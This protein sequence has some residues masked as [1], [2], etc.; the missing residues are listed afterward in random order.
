MI[1][2]KK[3]ISYSVLAIMLSSCFWRTWT[4]S[5][6]YKKNRESTLSMYNNYMKIIRQLPDR[7]LRLYGNA[8]M[9][10]TVVVHYKINESGGES[11][12]Y[13][14]SGEFI[15][16]YNRTTTIKESRK[17]FQTN[18]FKKLVSDF[19]KTNYLSISYWGDDEVFFALGNA[20]YNTREYIGILV[21]ENSN[22]MFIIKKI[23]DKAYVYEVDVP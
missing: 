1:K 22:P 14:S 13:S 6:Y 3:L 17:E 9:D 18:E 4:T 23:D 2:I 5:G 10:K 12:I 19:A 7:Y 11:A 20:R 15:S 8:G 21:T 16:G